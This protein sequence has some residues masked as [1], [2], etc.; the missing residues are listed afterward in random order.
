MAEPKG[1]RPSPPRY[2]RCPNCGA[3]RL[4]VEL[5]RVGERRVWGELPRSRCPDCGHE[6]PTS[7]FP[8]LSWAESHQM[9]ERR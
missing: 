8:Q 1:K 4:A 5:P 9:E 2:R 7:A 6:A 3:A